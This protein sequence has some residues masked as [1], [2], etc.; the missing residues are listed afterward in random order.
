[1]NESQSVVNDYTY[2]VE[3]LLTFLSGQSSYQRSQSQRKDKSPKALE[4]HGESAD[5]L[6]ATIKLIGN[7]IQKN[8]ELESLPPKGNIISDSDDLFSICPS[9]LANLPE[10]LRNTLSLSDSDIL[11]GRIIELLKIANRP[12]SVKEF[13]I[14]LYN[15]YQYEVEERNSFASK[16]YRMTQQELL[17]STEGKRGYY[18]LP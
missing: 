18:E 10:A 14:G 15:K 9:Q 2:T 1:M 11:E 7:Q 6:D 3:E 4:R 12:L 17:V 13:I 16:L 5:Y 8:Q